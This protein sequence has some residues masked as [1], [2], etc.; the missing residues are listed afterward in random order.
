MEVPSQRDAW[1][2]QNYQKLVK[3][4][5]NFFGSHIDGIFCVNQIGKDIKEILKFHK[6]DEMSP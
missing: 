4:P 5:L 6:N 1:K 3:D 2:S